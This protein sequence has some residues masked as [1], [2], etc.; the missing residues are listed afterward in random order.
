MADPAPPLAAV[1]ITLGLPAARAGTRRSGYDATVWRADLDDGTTAAVR[2][3]RAGMT[4]ER[5]V[6]ALRL[7]ARHT[8]LAPRLLATGVC[9]GRHALAL[10]WCPGRTL[11]DRLADGGDPVALGTAFGRIHHRLHRPVD[12]QVLCH[13]DYQPYNVLVDDGGGA[14][15]V[16]DWTN[17]RHADVRTDLARTAVVLALAPALVPDL[18]GLDMFARAW[19]EGY[20]SMPDDTSLRPFLA[21]AARHQLAE[22]TQRAAAGECPQTVVTAAQREVVR[23]T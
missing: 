18:H 22:W 6:T 9:D 17:A 5:D 8:D 1:L 16:V 10:S 19:R 3:L 14:T 2:L 13:L 20:G 15:G 21:A 4:A 23:W 11:G 12:G 7:A